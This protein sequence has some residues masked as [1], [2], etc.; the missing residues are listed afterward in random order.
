MRQLERR[1]NLIKKVICFVDLH[2]LVKS[3]LGLKREKHS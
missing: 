3:M 2:G 1:E